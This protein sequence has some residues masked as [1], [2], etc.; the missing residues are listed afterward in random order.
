MVDK[1]AFGRLADLREREAHVLLDAG[2]F[3]GA[4]YLAGYAV[5]CGLKAIIVE[6]FLAQDLPDRRL[7][8]EIYTHDLKKLARLANLEALTQAAPLELNWE[9]VFEWSE[10]SRYREYNEFDARRMLSSVSDPD[11]GVLS[12]LRL[13]W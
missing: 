2:Q 6:R 13:F 10:E 1:A 4:Y 9:I 5:E 12:C 8:I 3:S 11:H 7:V